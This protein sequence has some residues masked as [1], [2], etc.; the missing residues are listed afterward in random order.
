MLPGV[1]RGPCCSRSHRHYQYG[2]RYR[3]LDRVD[4]L[5]ACRSRR[6]DNPIDLRTE[7][8]AL[9]FAG[10]FEENGEA[11]GGQI[12]FIVAEHFKRASLRRREVEQAGVPT[13][14][15]PHGVGGG[16]SIVAQRQ[17]AEDEL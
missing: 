5:A 4:P 12:A 13:F 2:R 3:L 16:L 1:A 14:H 15:L 7:G 17:L 8:L 6:V 10:T 9:L 11:F